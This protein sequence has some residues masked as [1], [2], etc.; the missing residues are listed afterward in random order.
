[1]ESE[2]YAGGK[3]QQ[4]HE[5]AD[6]AEVEEEEREAFLCGHLSPPFFLAKYKFSPHVTISQKPHTVQQAGVL[7][8]SVTASSISAKSVHSVSVIIFYSIYG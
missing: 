7:M 2:E 1:M 6:A 8:R 5:G 4:S 3:S